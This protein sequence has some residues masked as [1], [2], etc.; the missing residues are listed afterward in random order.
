MYKTFRY[1]LFDI[2][3]SLSRNTQSTELNPRVISSPSSI[4]NRLIMALDIFY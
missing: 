2:F 1:N 3:I 4:Q